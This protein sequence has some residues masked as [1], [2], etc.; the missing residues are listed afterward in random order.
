M[1][2]A[3]TYRGEINKQ[4]QHNLFAFKV[5]DKKGQKRKNAFLLEH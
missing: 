3:I 1:V 4:S 5:N 2:E